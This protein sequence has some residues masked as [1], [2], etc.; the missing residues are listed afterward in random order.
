MKAK[1][2]HGMGFAKEKTV[3]AR[4]NGSLSTDP[5]E[6]GNFNRLQGK[7]SGTWLKYSESI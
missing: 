7:D 2:P 5:K 1:G 3:G 4:P 6:T